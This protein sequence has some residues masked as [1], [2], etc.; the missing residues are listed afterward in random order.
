MTI[1]TESALR[2][3][4]RQTLILEGGFENVSGGSKN[5]WFEFEASD[6]ASDPELAKNIFD[7]VQTAYANINGHLKFKD[8]RDISRNANF[9]VAIDTDDD[10]EADAVLISKKSNHGR[11]RMGVGHDGSN[12]AKKS[13]IDKMG[14]QMLDQ[15]VFA[16]VSGASAHILITR[17]DAPWVDKEKVDQVLAGK[18]IEWLGPHPDKKYPGYDG[19]YYRNIGGEKHIKIMLGNPK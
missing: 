11:K 1:I 5:K 7:L 18:D 4:I 17:Y 19:W 2:D 15:G 9:F 10:P 6:T 8:F 16:E 13:M 12:V 14:S 3:L